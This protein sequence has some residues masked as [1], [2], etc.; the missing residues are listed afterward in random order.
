LLYKAGPN[1]KKGQHWGSRIVFDKKGHLY[2]TIGD[3]GNRDVNPQDL[4]RDGGKV[5]RLNL[6][7]SIP[8]DNPFVNKAGAKEAVFSYG[9]R[10]PQGMTVSP[11]KLERCGKTNTDLE[12]ETKLTSSKK[13]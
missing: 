3:R 12:E 7:G 6:D 8:E 13:E 11:R 2:F 5:Y 10:N 9:H 4:S 1:S